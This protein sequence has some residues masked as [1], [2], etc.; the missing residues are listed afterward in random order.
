MLIPARARVA[1]FPLPRFRFRVSASA[2]TLP[3]FRFRVSAS[4][5]SATGTPSLGALACDRELDAPD[6]DG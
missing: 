2:F 6:A 5:A 4:A 1:R 3:R